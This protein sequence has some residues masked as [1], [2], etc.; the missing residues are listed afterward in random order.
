MKE[1]RV[2][3]DDSIIEKLAKAFVAARAADP[4]TQ[5]G[6]IMD[7]NQA[8][9]LVPD[10]RRQFASVKAVPALYDRILALWQQTVHA[11]TP[12]PRIIQVE[13]PTPVDFA[14]LARQLDTPTLV[15]LLTTRLG[16][17]LEGL[18]L[19]ASAGGASAVKVKSSGPPQLSVLAAAAPKR[20][21]P[22]VAFC[23]MNLEVFNKLCDEIQQ[24]NIPVDLRFVDAAKH[25]PQ[26][27]L[28]AD[29]VVF[30]QNSIINNSAFAL[31]R[32]NWPKDRVFVVPNNA[33]DTMTK[34]RE[35]STRLC[36]V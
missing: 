22:R 6:P 15:A 36:P 30:A 35:L 5:V 11:Q 16:E 3:W 21:P 8:E 31:A 28:T 29:F 34:L 33:T 14:E 17:A 20:R 32:S 7:K 10:Q 24:K 13:V 19:P 2:R 25:D 18:R 9:I 26:V 23:G 1:H 12:E 27:P 4:L